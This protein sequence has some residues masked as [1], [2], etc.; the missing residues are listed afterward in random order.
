MD[1]SLSE[2]CETQPDLQ[3]GSRRIPVFALRHGQSMHNVA[4]HNRPNRDVYFDDPNIWDSPLTLKGHRDALEVGSLDRNSPNC[5]TRIGEVTIVLVSPLA[6][7]LQTASNVW[8]I[9]IEEAGFVFPAWNSAAV[10]IDG[11]AW[12]GNLEEAFEESRKKGREMTESVS[13]LA[14]SG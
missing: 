14:E 9:A 3:S 11:Q 12:V 1:L 8:K 5:W 7:T 2:D 6:R 4:Y 13:E 10:E